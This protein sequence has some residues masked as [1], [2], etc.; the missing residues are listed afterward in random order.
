LSKNGPSGPFFMTNPS[1]SSDR[2]ELVLFETACRFDHPMGWPT[3]LQLQEIFSTH[4]GN[5]SRS[6]ASF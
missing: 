3:Q 6:R 2:V 5:R 4:T 1:I